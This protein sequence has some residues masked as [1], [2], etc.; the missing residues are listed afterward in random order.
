MTLPVSG[1]HAV[2]LVELFPTEVLGGEA[3]LI[4]LFLPADGWTAPVARL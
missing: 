3:I 1:E 4:E 2:L